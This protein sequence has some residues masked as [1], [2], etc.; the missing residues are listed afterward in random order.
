MTFH[1]GIFVVAAA[2]AAVFLAH[3]SYRR[4]IPPLSPRLRALLTVVRAAAYLLIFFLV[5]DPRIVRRA[6]RTEP[7]TVIGLIDQSESMSLPVRGWDA[8]RAPSRY[9]AARGMAAG[10]QDAVEAAGAVFRPLA[11]SG[12][13]VYA[14]ADS[15]PPTGQGTDI[16]SAVAQAVSGFEG[17][18]IAGVVLFSDGADTE[19]SLVRRG[20]LPAPVFAFG[21]GD[22]IAPEDVRIKEVD[23]SSIVG[24]PSRASIRAVLEYSGGGGAA[25]GGRKHIRLRLREGERT[26]FER[27]TVFAGSSGEL[28][29]DI[30]VEF[31]E[32]GTRRFTLDVAVSG[33]DAEEDNNR[34]EIVVHAEKSERR[35]LIVDL[36]PTWELTFLTALLRSEPTFDFTVVAP[37]GG[38]PSVSS[39]RLVDK[40][41]LRESLGEAD[42]LV[43]ASLDRALAEEEA[44]AIERFVRE[45]G[46]GLL[47][48]PGPGSLFEHPDAWSRLSGLLPVQAAPPLRF[49]LGYTVLREGPQGASHP[50]TSPLSGRFA[51]ADWQERS[52]LLGVYTPLAPKPGAEILLETA[53]S[54][55]PAL[56]VHTAGSGRVALLAAGPLWRWKFLASD[57]SVYDQ[58]ISRLFDYLS[59][60]AQAERFILR[61]SKNVYDSGEPARVTGEV[62]DEKM[63]PVT[64]APVQVELSRIGGE[65]G[66]DVPL[67]VLPMRRE[68]S[69]NARFEAS[70]PPL[71][72]GRYRLRGK[73][74]LGG[75]AIESPAVDIT[76]SDVSV[77]FQRV[78]QDRTNLEMIAS[79]SGGRYYAEADAAGLLGRLDLEAVTRPTTSEIILRANVAVFGLII[80]LLGAEWIIRKRVGM[81]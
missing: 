15:A 60:G 80:L 76:V 40:G 62:F 41:R 16:R 20:A 32:P 10:I 30:P 49:D 73:A 70:L 28:S 59:R 5:T 44:S 64:G 47:V 55:A 35:I 78:N 14:A 11:F 48:L 34:R 81:I 65:G 53:A 51:Q 74:D 52:P 12:G 63:Q 4:T 23:Y 37:L 8:D 1:T 13:A 6:E 67:S 24:A 54:R 38:H 79:Q 27:D 45:D 75:R 2:A 17:R 71:G 43:I 21:L 26:V 46:K 61:A 77:E 18:K 19:E 22:T 33:Y 50:V 58:L 25:E 31:P 66:E 56:V 9:A 68:G 42:A 69:D 29:R 57:G 3:L 7:A 39:E 36:A 72:G